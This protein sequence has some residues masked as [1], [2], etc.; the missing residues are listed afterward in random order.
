M[1]LGS[2]LTCYGRAGEEMCFRSHIFGQYYNMLKSFTVF[3]FVRWGG[4][5]KNWCFHSTYPERSFAWDD[6][7]RLLS[8]RLIL[9]RCG[10]TLCYLP[11]LKQNSKDK[12]RLLKSWRFKKVVQGR[13]DLLPYTVTGVLSASLNEKVGRLDEIWRRRG[14]EEC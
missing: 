11:L 12:P 5:D 8:A 4:G 14:N 3:L 10:G 1:S 6:I 7:K 13:T 2:F 9:C